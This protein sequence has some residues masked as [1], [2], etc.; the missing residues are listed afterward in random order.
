MI[1]F[2]KYIVET[3]EIKGNL[4]FLRYGGLSPVKQKGEKSP[5]E[6]F[7]H[8]P[9]NRGVYA[10]VWPWIE[11]F[12]I[13]TGEEFDS[14]RQEF[15]RDKEGNR[16]ESPQELTDENQKIWDKYEK[17]GTVKVKGKRYYIR[18]KKPKK[19]Q[20]KGNIWHHLI[21]TKPHKVIKRKGSWILT[22][23]ETYKRL[24]RKELGAQSRM[25]TVY[26]HLEVFIEKI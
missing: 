4:T 1:G 21:D 6:T 5:K 3:K 8:P 22:D 25:R 16:I 14:R 2:K 7:H 13:G 24:L 26:D 19:F 18:N 17:Y 20:Y 23:M 12:L 11:P 10:F 9:A 15:M